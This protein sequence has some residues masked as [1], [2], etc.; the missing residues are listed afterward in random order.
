[1]PTM[2]KL[3]RPAGSR[4][5]VQVRREQDQRRGS[6]TSRG[7]TGRW[8]KAAASFRRSH[9]LCEYCALEGK[10]EASTLVDHLYPHRVFDGVFW[11]VE[12]WVAS[13]DPCHSGMKQAV[14]RAGKAAIDA[15]ARR[16][17]RAVMSD[18]PG[19]G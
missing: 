18:P 5:G 3:L 9:P 10:A 2:P 15:L 17:G 1:M 6:S 19:G 7:Y 16:L 8:A 12:W 11:L 14:E 4:S 13:C